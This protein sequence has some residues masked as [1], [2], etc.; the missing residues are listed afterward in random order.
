MH[1]TA[2]PALLNKFDAPF[3]KLPY[4]FIILDCFKLTSFW[5]ISESFSVLSTLY[6]V[7]VDP[8]KI[9]NFSIVND[10]Y[11]EDRRI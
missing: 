6:T 1:P 3:V 10:F 8:K 9:Y 4:N 11:G 2:Q 7:Q 5:G